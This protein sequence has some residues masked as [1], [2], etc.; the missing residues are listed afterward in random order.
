MQITCGACTLT[1]S[2]ETAMLGCM[3]LA[4]GLALQEVGYKGWFMRSLGK[5]CEG[6]KVMNHEHCVVAKR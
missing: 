6:R 1:L 4:I 3:D 2:H 5:R